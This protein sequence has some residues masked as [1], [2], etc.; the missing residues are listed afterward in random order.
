MADNR[1][2]MK[3]VSDDKRIVDVDGYVHLVDGKVVCFP[4]GLYDLSREDD[5]NRLLML[6]E[7]LYVEKTMRAIHGK[8]TV[9]ILVPMKGKPGRSIFCLNHIGEL[10]VE[11]Q[12]TIRRVHDGYRS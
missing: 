7:D 6:G 11:V 9:C 12:E 5:R 1:I 3:W 4:E 8:N 10:P 2:K